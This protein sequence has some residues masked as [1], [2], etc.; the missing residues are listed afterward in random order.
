MVIYKTRGTSWHIKTP[1]YLVSNSCQI[2]E[3][4]TLWC[5][6]DFIL[7]VEFSFCIWSSLPIHKI[8]SYFSIWNPL[9]WR[10][11]PEVM[12]SKSS[13][14]L[15]LQIK[16]QTHRP[17]QGCANMIF[18]ISIFGFWVFGV[19]FLHKFL[20]LPNP[21]FNHMLKTFTFN[22]PGKQHQQTT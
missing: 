22:H 2:S 13:L 14:H 3:T 20:R 10:M 5:I 8:R 15:P 18:Q 12:W 11:K 7:K 17:R 4:S 6:K 16:T 19:L 9:Q 21:K 1:S